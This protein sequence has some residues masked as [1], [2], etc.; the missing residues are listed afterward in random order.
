VLRPSKRRPIAEWIGTKFDV[1]VRRACDIVRIY[2]ST[3]YYTPADRSYDE[4]L[5]MKIR[6]IAGSRPRFGY[7]RITVMLRREGI[8][9]GKDRVYRIYLEEGMNLNKKGKK[10]KRLSFTR[11][12]PVP[13]TKPGERWSI[14]FISDRLTDGRHFRSLTVVDQYSRKC[15]GVIAR[16]SFPAH[17]VTAALDKLA[18]DV[19]VYPQSITLDNGPEFRGLVF[20]LWANDREINLDFIAPGKPT[21]NGFVES[22]NGRLRDEFLNLNLFR[23]LVRLRH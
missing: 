11:V 12:T 22:F 10:R 8:K 21:Q 18:K 19:G 3:Y 4:F 9:V 14:D 17:E 20:D 13:A 1:S 7:R 2:R 6:E 23:T 16:Y 5:R 15:I